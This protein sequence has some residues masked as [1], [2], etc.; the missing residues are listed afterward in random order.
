MNYSFPH[1]KVCIMKTVCIII[2]P[3]NIEYIGNK[4]STK[5]AGALKFKLHLQTCN[6]GELI[7]IFILMSTTCFST[8]IRHWVYTNTRCNE[9]DMDKLFCAIL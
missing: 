8:Y 2:Y 9:P 4:T 7:F 6:K 3:L 5:Y 1:N